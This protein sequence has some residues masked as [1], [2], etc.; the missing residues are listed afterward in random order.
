MWQL[1]LEAVPSFQPIRDAFLAEWAPDGEPLPEFNC[2]R[3][4]A[5]FTVK[6]YERGDVAAVQ[7][8]FDVVGLWLREGDDNVSELAVVG[9]VEDLS[10]GNIHTVTKPEDFERF[11]SPEV[12]A[13]WDSMIAA[14]SRRAKRLD[15]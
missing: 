1:L 5:V 14:W 6:A 11:M 8:I 2:T 4:L 15:Q 7:R 13:E 10:V 3:E 12:K 9:F